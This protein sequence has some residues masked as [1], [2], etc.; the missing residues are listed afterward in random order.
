[1]SKAIADRLRKLADQY[2]CLNLGGVALVLVGT[3]E[4]QLGMASSATIGD[5]NTDATNAIS[6]VQAMNS[7]ALGEIKR[8]VGLERL[9]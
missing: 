8:V 7:A 3:A 1:M 4:I 6:L 9:H 2:E 5:E